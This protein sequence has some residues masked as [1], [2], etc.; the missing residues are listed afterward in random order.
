[1]SSIME[2][3]SNLA[4]DQ[5]IIKLTQERILSKIEMLEIN[6]QTSKQNLSGTSIYLDSSFCDYFPMQNADMFLEV[7]HLITN[8]KSFVDKLEYFI[9]NIGGC[10]LKNYIKRTLRKLF[11]DDYATRCT[12]PGRDKGVITKIGDS[13]VLKT[14]KKVIKEVICAMVKKDVVSDS[15]IETIVADWFRYSNTR[16]LRSTKTSK[17]GQ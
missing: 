3:L 7:E 6:S 8:D 17:Q 5:N 1:M 15:E 16:L 14:I 10:N 9:K 13:E 4:R 2:M 12:L 11:S